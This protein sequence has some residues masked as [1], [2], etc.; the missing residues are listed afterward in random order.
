MRFSFNTVIP[1]SRLIR[2][3]ICLF[4]V[5]NARHEVALKPTPIT[6]IEFASACGNFF[7]SLNANSIAVMGVG[8]SATSCLALLTRNNQ[9]DALISLDGGITVLNE[10]RM[11]QLTSFYDPVA[12]NKPML[13]IYSSHPDVSTATLDEYKYSD[14][15]F[16]HVPFMREFDCTD[17]GMLQRFSPNMIGKPLGDTGLGSEWIYNYMLNF[18]NFTLRNDSPAKSFITNDPKANNVPEGLIIPSFKKALRTPPSL[19][20]LKE[21]VAEKGA[22]GLTAIYNEL[23]PQDS[24][25]FSQKCMADFFSW[26]GFLRDK[27]FSIR[28]ELARIWLESYPQSSRGNFVLARLL[29]AKGEK[30]KS[31]AAYKEALRLLDSDTDLFLDN[32]TR[33]R[34][35]TTA[36]AEINKL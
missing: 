33:T 20:E 8:F 10:K 18:L 11:L 35:R 9:I 29:G 2:A 25:P 22:P 6:A 30:E 32:N 19:L 13:V 15:Y 21:L 16:F 34:I 24:Q 36:T 17:F 4:R 5:S 27:D 12:I 14:R 7:T 23:K 28:T 3:S 31:L 1:P 26:L